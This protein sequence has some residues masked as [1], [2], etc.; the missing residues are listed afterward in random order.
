MSLPYCLLT[1][2][3]L[4]HISL[5]ASGRMVGC[6]KSAINDKMPLHAEFLRSTHEPHVKL[7]PLGGCRFWRDGQLYLA[8]FGYAE[9]VTGQI[10]EAFCG[11]VGQMKVTVMFFFV[12]LPLT[13]NQSPNIMVIPSSLPYS[14]MSKVLR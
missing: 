7:H 1:T 6:D 3:F 11:V 14:A 2:I 5:P 9:S 8:A 4:P 13:T 12:T 10:F